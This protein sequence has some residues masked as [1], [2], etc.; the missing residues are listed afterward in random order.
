MLNGSQQRQQQRHTH[1]QLK[2]K[3]NKNINK[4]EEKNEIDARIFHCS[5]AAVPATRKGLSF[6]L[7]IIVVRCACD[8]FTLYTFSFCFA[9]VS[10]LAVVVAEHTHLL[11]S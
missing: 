6:L 1:K 5:C 11:A 2:M 7:A 10:M 9:V 4:S 8:H 3:T